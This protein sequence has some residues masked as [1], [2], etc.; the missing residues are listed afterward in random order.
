[1]SPCN[2]KSGT[3]TMV[4]PPGFVNASSINSILFPPLVRITATTGLSP[5][6]IACNAA[7]CTPRNCMVAWPVICRNACVISMVFNRCRCIIWFSSASSSHGSVL[8]N[9]NM[10]WRCAVVLA[11]SIIP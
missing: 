1:M 4:V 8:D 7:A 2:N 3:T 10:C 9:R 11:C 5:F 6:W